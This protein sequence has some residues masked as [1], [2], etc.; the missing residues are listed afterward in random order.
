MKLLLESFRKYLKED[1]GSFARQMKARHE[2][3]FDLRSSFDP[4]DVK[5]VSGPDWYEDR[6]FIVAEFPVG[7]PRWS[8]G[9][10]GPVEMDD[11]MKFGFY[12]SLGESMI[13]TDH[14]AGTW[15]PTTGVQEGDGWIMKIPEKYA[16]PESLLG[17]VGRTLTATHGKRWQEYNKE[18]L[19]KRYEAAAASKTWGAY[20][21]DSVEKQIDNINN[22]FDHE[23]VY[24]VNPEAIMGMHEDK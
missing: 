1:D 15:V 22:M 7:A 12:T 8:I 3:P 19:E 16:H 24:K 2:A 18:K 5:V 17:L 10:F 4:R 23:G 20:G 14:L 9:K 13:D 11:T 6:L 21:K